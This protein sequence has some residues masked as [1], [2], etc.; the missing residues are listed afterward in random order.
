MCK[1]LRVSRSGFYA[2][3]GREESGRARENRRLMTL[4]RKAFDE[5]R[6]IYGAPRVHRA[7]QQTGELCGLNR[8]ARLMRNAD[9]RS[10]TRRRFRV[11]T[12]DSNHNHPIAPDRFPR[13]RREPG[14][15]LG[16]DLHPDR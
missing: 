8:V 1:T 3:C 6:G 9:L 12:T 13:K 7:L 11:K 15:G 5:S 2:W 4:I 10:K 16:P 14:L